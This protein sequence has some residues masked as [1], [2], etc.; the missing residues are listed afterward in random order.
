MALDEAAEAGI[1]LSG[2]GRAAE[3]SPIREMFALAEQY[4]GEEELVRLEIGEPDFHTPAHIVDAAAAAAKAGATHY[5]PNAGLLELRQAIAGKMAADNDVEFDPVSEIVVTNGAMEAIYLGL[6]ATV[7]PG[8]RVVLPTPCWPNYFMQVQLVGAEPVKVPL[9]A[10]SGFELDPEPVVEAIDG[11]T[12]AVLLNSPNNPT[13]RLYDREGIR[14]V[15]EAAADHGAVVIADEV[16]EGLIYEGD[17]ASAATYVD[18]PENV[19]VVNACSKKY[20]MTGWRLGWLAGESGVIDAAVKFHQATTSSASS[21][22][23]M[24]ALEAI[25]GDQA[26]IHEMKAAFQE[27]RD[28]VVGRVEEIPGI[29]CPRPEGAIYAF[30]DVGSLDGS[31]FDV[32][33]RLL[34]DYGVVT[35]P[36]EGFGAEG[37]HI[38]ISTATS[39][40]QLEMGLD[41]IEAM[42]DDEL[43]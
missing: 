1:R 18:H 11:R 40:D 12:A 30:L 6:L 14:A 39:L 34:T 27:R 29:S 23:Q 7:D 35:V 10:E 42:V 33:K 16:Y 20:A 4:D 31:D 8:E 36:G 15:A 41:R 28:Y 3:G 17:P 43:V 24:A 32:A 22:S 19:L 13:G 2:R 37:A 9:P 25:T 26:P 38:R 5:T 21:V